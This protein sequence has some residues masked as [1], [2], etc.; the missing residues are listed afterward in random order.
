MSEH[1]R[2]TRDAS[3][4]FQSETRDA[5]GT[6]ELHATVR[7]EKVMHVRFSYRAPHPDIADF[8]ALSV[9]LDRRVETNGGEVPD[10]VKVDY[11]AVSSETEP[12]VGLG[13]HDA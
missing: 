3:G 8:E 7:V 12:W 4:G 9:E 13:R 1:R 2:G 6:F 5:L 11:V 10:D